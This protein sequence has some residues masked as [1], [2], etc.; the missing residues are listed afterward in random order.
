MTELD[1]SELRPKQKKTLDRQTVGGLLLIA[2]TIISLVIANSPLDHAYHEILKKHFVFGL[3]DSYALD[4]SLHHW[5]NDGLMV[6]FFLVAGMEMKREILVGELSSRQQAAMPL[7]AALGGMIVPAGIFLAL[8]AG[9]EAS[10]G[11]A[12]PMATDIAYALGIMG[13]L[14]KRVPPQLKIFLIALAI[15][16]DVGAILI[17]AIFYSHGISWAA[18]GMA[19]GLYLILIVMNIQGV[20]KLS[21]YLVVGF[22]FW[23]CFLYSGVHATIAGV[24]FALVIPVLPSYSTSAFRERLSGHEAS[25]SDLKAKDLNPL[26][27][28]HQSHFLHHARRDLKK[29]QA[30]LIRLEHSLEGF[31]S[32]IVIPLFALVNAGVKLN[33]PVQELFS[34]PLG[35]GI[36]LGLL[37]GKVLGVFAFSWASV[38][39]GM[40]KL[41]DNLTWKS[42][43][44]AGFIAGIGFTMSLFITNL[45][46]TDNDE[47][48]KISKISILLASTLAG[49]IGA[50]LLLKNKANAS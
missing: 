10:T 2:A 34:Q 17:I 14:G 29:S 37:I 33:V 9:G 47:F 19:A 8:N 43:L 49:L 48:I 44:G 24:L 38:K 35:L 32:Y 21:L 4:L 3:D 45:A 42:I 26:T 15:A 41:S 30:P 23:I 6:I 20:K 18:L 40:A 28:A 11:W 7:M 1:D 5:I 50:L 13:L 25:W 22:F 12:I 36:I 31:N 16:D 39:M 27:D 46:F